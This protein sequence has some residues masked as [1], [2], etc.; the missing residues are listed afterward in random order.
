MADPAAYIPEAKL[1]AIETAALQSCDANDGVK[2]GVLDTPDRCQFKPAAL[3][4]TGPE[5]D[6]CL[7]AAQG[8]GLEKIL[9]G[10]R[11]A[12]GSL[13]PGQVVGGITGGGGWA[14]WITGS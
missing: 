5:S 7:T 6:G 11:G 4:C 3:L 10:V 2:D 14:A 9:S 1:R 13:F 8:A 12:K